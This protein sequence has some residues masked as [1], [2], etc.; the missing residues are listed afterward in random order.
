LIFLHVVQKN[1]SRLVQTSARV[2]WRY[3]SFWR[4]WNFFEKWFVLSHE[5]DSSKSTWCA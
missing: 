3:A 4:M 1:V 2:I 5:R